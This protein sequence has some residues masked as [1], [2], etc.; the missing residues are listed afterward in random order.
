MSCAE[1][2]VLRRLRTTV[3]IKPATAKPQPDEELIDAL[4]RELT[5]ALDLFERLLDGREYLF[6]EFSAADC[7]AFPFLKYAVDDN[8]EDDEGE[9][10][11]RA[12]ML[13]GSEFGSMGCESGKS[14][15]DQNRTATSM[16][17]FERVL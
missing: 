11:T 1:T 5:G 2:P 14:R 4:G 3:A 6:G 16:I 15:Q 8:A 10:E 17:T 7:A 9:R 13:R 12:V